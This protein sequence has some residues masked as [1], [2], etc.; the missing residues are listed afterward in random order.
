MSKSG[1]GH[2]AR[3]LV[4]GGKSGRSPEGHGGKRPHGFSIFGRPAKGYGG[5]K[6]GGPAGRSPGK[7]KGLGGL[8]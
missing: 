6:K 2:S 8:F 3:R 5:S 4:K 7:Y 1:S